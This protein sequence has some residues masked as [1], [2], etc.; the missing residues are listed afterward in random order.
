MAMRFSDF[1]ASTQKAL[2]AAYDE[3]MSLL[4]EDPALSLD[5]I[6]R[7]R[8][9]VVQRLCELAAGG[10]ISRLAL[11]DAAVAVILHNRATEPG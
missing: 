2:F 6:V 4:S 7:F 10:T 8:T 9:V 5:L 3:A 1:D 11:R